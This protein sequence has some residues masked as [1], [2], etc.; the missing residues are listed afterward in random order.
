VQASLHLP[1]GTWN[2][3]L[4]V[5]A[6]L[7]QTDG[8]PVLD[9]LQIG[10]LPLPTWL[11]P[12]LWSAAVARLGLK[13]EW[14]LALDVFRGLHFQP[15]QLTL[16]YQLG[17]D[18]AARIVAALVPPAEQ[19]RL[20]AYSDRLT[21]LAAQDPGADTRSLAA[22]IGPIFALARQRSRAAADTDADARAENRAALVVLT[23][24]ANG[25]SLDSVLPAARQWPRPRPVR[26]TL[27][28]RDDSPL[29]LLISAALVVEG[30]SA[31]SQAVG[32]YKEVAD[33]RG[34]SGFSFNDLAAD[35]AGTRLGELALEQPQRLQ[36]LLA[37]GVS[38]ADFMPRAADLP[39]AMP[40]PEFK[41]RFGGVSEP[42]YKAMLAEID[43][44][45]GALAAF[46]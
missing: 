10:A 23:L 18:S 17:A 4:N 28:G 39:E 7:H 36:Q 40:E 14:R 5:T 11:G 32:L 8:L 3:W 43:R 44:R 29:H 20:K 22:W 9:D 26:L 1:A 24:Y 34:G 33:S 45:V 13:D 38:E 16:S 42:R 21:D 25:K 31:L 35:R 37:R 12:P 46:H 41:R 30:S 19:E 15:R 2:G 27:A 6:G